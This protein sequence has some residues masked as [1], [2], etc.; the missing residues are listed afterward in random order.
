MNIIVSLMAAGARKKFS[1]E[2]YRHIKKE[3]DA[4]YRRLMSENRDIPKALKLFKP[5]SLL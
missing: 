3:A 4:R 5:V 1:K 2:E